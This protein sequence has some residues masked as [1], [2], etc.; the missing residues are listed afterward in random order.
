MSASKKS[1]GLRKKY[2]VLIVE[3]SALMRK[4]LKQIINS[5]EYL[6]VIGTAHDGNE[7]LQMAKDLKPD[8]ITLD[9]NLPKMDGLTL[10]QH[11]M[12]E[13][14][15]PCIMISAYT[16]LG[17]TETFDAIDYG[18]V[19]FVEKPSGEI[20]RDLE[21]KSKEIRNKIRSALSVNLGI[22]TR[23]RKLDQI[24]RVRPI[25]TNVTKPEKAIV[26]GVST[27][28][29]RTLMQLLPN[30]PNDIGC[31]VIVVQHMPGKYT[32]SFAERMDKYCQMEVKEAENMELVQN[33]TI[34]IA[35]GD[36]NLELY[37]NTYE[38]QIKFIATT[39]KENLIYF[40]N[41]NNT[42]DSAISLF[43]DRTIGVILT[44][45]G[46][47]GCKAMVKLH[48]LGG[49]TIAESEESAIIYGMPK[50]VVDKK[51]AVRVLPIDKIANSLVYELKGKR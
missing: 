4:V 21:L 31:P 24:E 17:S 25:N 16:K 34:Y 9:I 10:L 37:H 6:T 12:I 27:G 41:V 51:A 15:A 18:A 45:M 48:K 30:L 1:L 29:P 47:D 33:N 46:E 22:V 26:I 49:I 13:A 40:P 2:K 35:P 19:D 32:K 44:G 43:K 8:V 3:D 39:P 42:M 20:S 28:G 38:D 11:I 36:M 50:A 23:Q 5:D 14:P 7:G